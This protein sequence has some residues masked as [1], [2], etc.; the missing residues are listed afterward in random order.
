MKKLNIIGVKIP[1]SWITGTGKEKVLN[2]ELKNFKKD[3][4]EK[5]LMK[6][7]VPPIESKFWIKGQDKKGY[8]EVVEIKE[9]RIWSDEKKDWTPTKGEY[10]VNLMYSKDGKF[11]TWYGIKKILSKKDVGLEESIGGY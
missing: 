9:G 2:I 1:N 4:I 10:E 7:G 6:V 11:Y 5:F 3:N 8:L